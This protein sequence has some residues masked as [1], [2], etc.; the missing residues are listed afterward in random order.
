MKLFFSTRS[1]FTRKVRLAIAELGA[2][3]AIDLVAAD[4]GFDRAPPEALAI[5]NPLA[6]LPTFVAEDGTA[7]FGSGVICEWL[8]QRFAG[9]LCPADDRIEWRRRE[10]IADGMAEKTLRRLVESGRGNAPAVAALEDTLWR[11]LAWIERLPATPEQIDLGWIAIANALDYLDFRAVD[12]D[13]RGRFPQLSA[14]HMIVTARASFQDTCFAAPAPTA[15]RPQ[16]D[17]SATS[18]EPQQC[19]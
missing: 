4:V 9:H 5:A 11:S 6:Q 17:T 10:V 8:D 19:P 18:L 2:T 13:W 15:A 14:W 7:I 1:P 16:T 12:L 3:D